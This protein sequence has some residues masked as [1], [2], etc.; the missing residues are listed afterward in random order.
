MTPFGVALIV[1]T[2]VGARQGGYAGD[3]TVWMNLLAT[4]A[5]WLVTHPNVANAAAFQRLPGNAHYVEG[6]ALD[7]WLMG[8]CQL[9]PVRQQRLGVVLDAGMEPG[10]NVLHRNTV[11]AVQQVYGVPVV[12]VAETP[13]PLRLRVAMTPAGVS[14][15]HLDNPQVLIESARTLMAKGATAIA[16]AS[17]IQ[18]PPDSLYAEGL[19]VD[20]IGGLEAIVSHTLV[21]A[22][23]IPCANAPVFSWTEAAP[24]R[25]QLLSANV[26]AEYITATFLPSVLT[27]LHRA[28]DLLWLPPVA[29]A[30]SS[31]TLLDRDALAAVVVPGGVL[32]GPAVLSALEQRIPVVVVTDNPT[33]LCIDASALW[34][35]AVA[36]RLVEQ[37]RLVAVH[38]YLEAAGLLQLW[39]AGLSLPPY[40]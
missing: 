40:R 39:R 22:L 37:G 6:Y 21:R 20:P 38:S 17:V 16:V 35:E 3:A 32:G 36:S 27:G 31:N 1:P 28:P 23:G 26:A 7:A 4:T 33:A 19:G 8:R 24:R 10:M 2:G 13:E 34:G 29:P 18:E 11:T 14:S 25:D 15:G 30:V 12:C 5:D 9:R